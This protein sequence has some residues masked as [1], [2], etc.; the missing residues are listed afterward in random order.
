MIQSDYLMKF[1]NEFI[2]KIVEKARAKGA[3]A[4]HAMENKDRA[5]LEEFEHEF[6]QYPGREQRDAIQHLYKQYQEMEPNALL[7]QALL[8]A[9]RI[10]K[11]SSG[12]YS[13]EIEAMEAA[14]NA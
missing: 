14:V 1:L 13:A 3:E 12:I 7:R 4:E 2:R 8:S 10:Y 6:S 11:Q 5:A 9:I